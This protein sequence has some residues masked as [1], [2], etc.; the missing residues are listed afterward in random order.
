MALCGSRWPPE[1]TMNLKVMEADYTVVT[2]E[3]GH[4][5]QFPNI[6]SRLWLAQDSPPWTRF[7]IKKEK[8]TILMA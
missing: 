2:G 3:P 4:S 6:D 8:G 7:Y 5:D 1:G